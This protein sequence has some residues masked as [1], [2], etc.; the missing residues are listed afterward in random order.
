MTRRLFSAGF[1]LP[2][3]AI[4]LVLGAKLA[5]IDKLGSDLPVGEQWTVEGS[6][7][8]QVKARR[9][10]IP[11]EHFFF[12]SGEHRPVMTRYWAYALFVADGNQWDCRVQAVANLVFQA[13][14]VLV[15]WFAAALFASAGWLA[16]LRGLTVALCALPANHENFTWG[17]QS[18]FLLC[19]LC[20]LAHVV[21]TAGAVK[22]T[23]RWVLAQLAGLVGILSLASGLLSAAALVGLVV[24][25]WLRGRRGSWCWATLLVNGGLLAFGAWFAVK[26]AS[27]SN[28]AHS[29]GAF[30]RAFSVLLTWPAPAGWGLLSHVPFVV[31]GVYALRRPAGPGASA[32]FLG[33]GA[34]FW[35]LLGALAYG[36][37]GETMSIAVRY[38]DML[39]LGCWLNVGAVLWLWREKAGGSRTGW[40]AAVL[41]LCLLPMLV[42]LAYWNRPAGIRSTIGSVGLVAR[43][44]DDVARDFLK[45]DDPAVFKRYD[46]LDSRFPHLPYTIDILR[47]PLMRPALPPSLQL[48]GRAGWLSRAAL[49]ATL[50]WRGLLVAGGLLLVLGSWR[51]RKPA[52]A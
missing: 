36:R 31:A 29:V 24:V 7:L 51:G 3:G 6:T 43:L 38:F 27:A 23:G 20:G 34:W 22:P 39:V 40:L 35:L 16:V 9:G 26:G 52:G 37:G 33:L 21:G 46:W 11:V 5:L 15:L 17:F 32:C 13:G 14:I 10:H 50:Q 19:I 18:Q 49:W 45:T 1:L 25:E 47:D 28:H 8:F 4:L 41:G 48:D 42:W 44:R 2:L 12:P 30:L